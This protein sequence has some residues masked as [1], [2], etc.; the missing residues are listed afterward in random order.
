MGEAEAKVAEL[1]AK[2]AALNGELVACDPADWKQ[3]QEKTDALKAIE[4]E[5]AY[6]MTEWE[7]RQ[8]ALEKSS[9]RQRASPLLGF[10]AVLA[11]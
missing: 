10:L 2:A 11:R 5:L 6:A 4:M 3:F 8:R 1:E 9:E 7:E